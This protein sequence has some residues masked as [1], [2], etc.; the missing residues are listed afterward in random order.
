MKL[1]ITHRMAGSALTVYARLPEK[2][3]ILQMPC[4]R[5]GGAELITLVSCNVL[6][7]V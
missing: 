2:D 1:P 5:V 3:L 7:H 6:L 4:F